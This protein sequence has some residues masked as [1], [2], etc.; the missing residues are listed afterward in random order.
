MYT[1]NPAVIEILLSAGADLE[2]R[3]KND[4][5]PLHRAAG[6]NWNAAVTEG[7]NRGRGRSEGEG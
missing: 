2:A 4:Y 1:E 3:D 7:P 5:T 6:S